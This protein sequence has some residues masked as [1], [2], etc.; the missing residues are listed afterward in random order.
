MSRSSVAQATFAEVLWPAEG[1][2]PLGRAILLALLGSVLLTLS[3][4]LQVPF[5]PVPMT[6]QTLVVLL[7]G[8]ALGARLGAAAVLLYLAEGAIGLPVFA[9]TPAKGVGIAYMLGPTGGYLLGFLLAAGLA[10]WLV[11]RRRDWAGLAAAV[12]AGMI[13]IYV[14]GVLWL[15]GFVGMDGAVS[16]GVVP[17]LFGDLLK[18]VLATVLGLAGAA[19]IERR[20]AERPER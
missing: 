11:E 8:M 2:A 3:A 12:V 5:Y 20:L 4:K 16:L 17:F 18:A 14:P 6:M 9:G 1:R 15:S 7:L 19:L 13:T 10:G